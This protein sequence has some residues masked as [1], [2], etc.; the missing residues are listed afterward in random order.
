[1]VVDESSMAYKMFKDFYIPPL[2]PA[3]EHLKLPSSW[4]IH[5]IEKSKHK[6]RAGLPSISIQELAA[7]YK[8]IDS[9][10]KAWLEEMSNRLH[11]YNREMCDILWR[12]I[13]KQRQAKEAKDIEMQK[14]NEMAKTMLELN[15]SEKEMKDERRVGVPMSNR[16]SNFVLPPTPRELLPL[17]MGLIDPGIGPL[18]PTSNPMVSGRM[19][20]SA[21]TSRPL[22]SAQEE[23][24]KRQHGEGACSVDNSSREF[25]RARIEGPSPEE[26]FALDPYASYL[27]QL[28]TRH[29]LL[30][31]RNLGGGAGLMSSQTFEES[32]DRGDQ[33]LL[34]F[35]M[36]ML[37]AARFNT[38]ASLPPLA[39][40]QDMLPAR[41]AGESRADVFTRSEF[42]LSY[43][44]VMDTFD[45]MKK[46][47]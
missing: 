30:G 12:Y 39:P 22:P 31:P 46:H 35:K 32:A 47:G 14:E 27:A 37:Q 10:T 26:A 3:Y 19:S 25:K 28:R 34:G 6:L 15:E 36:G 18:I 45:E 44:D 7:E 41:Q 40:S 8:K 11:T 13:K 4:F 21:T 43:K 9:T 38:W 23:S 33:I 2:P 29:P 17:S 42:G 24:R 5:S 20:S 16:L 1:M